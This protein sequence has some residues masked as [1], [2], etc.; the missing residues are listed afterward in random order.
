M[1]AGAEVNCFRGLVH[2]GV[3][4]ADR[5]SIRNQSLTMSFNLQLYRGSKTIEMM[6]QAQKA[7][8]T[9]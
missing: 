9:V 7:P 2:V 1:A 8:D 4:P 6:R 3:V 5:R